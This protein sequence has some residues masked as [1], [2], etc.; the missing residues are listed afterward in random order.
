MLELSQS[1]DSSDF[2]IFTHWD[3]CW[4]SRIERHVAAKFVLAFSFIDYH[5]T[6]FFGFS[7]KLKKTEGDATLCNGSDASF[8]A[9]CSVLFFMVNKCANVHSGSVISW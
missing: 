2:I 6:R 1:N 8:L 7:A 5:P 3:F 4:E 9:C